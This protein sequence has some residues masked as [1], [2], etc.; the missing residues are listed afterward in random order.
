MKA[1]G[2]ENESGSGRKEVGVANH[3]LK[4]H[5]KP[6]MQVRPRRKHRGGRGPEIE[7]VSLM[8]GQKKREPSQRPEKG[9]S[10]GAP[11][12]PQACGQ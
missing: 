1:V 9:R 3:H 11:P 4:W 7:Q 6:Q 5:S 10:L 8:D 2:A 12:L